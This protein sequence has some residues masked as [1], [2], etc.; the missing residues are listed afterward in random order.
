MIPKISGAV[1]VGGRERANYDIVS[2]GFYAAEDLKRGVLAPR[3]FYQINWKLK[4]SINFIKMGLTQNP[5][6]WSVD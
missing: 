3:N 1:G 5:I 2:D 6:Y 4:S